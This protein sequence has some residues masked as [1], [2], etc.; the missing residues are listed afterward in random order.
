MF[1]RRRPVLNPS[2]PN[3]IGSFDK[4]V[5]RTLPVLNH[6]DNPGVEFSLGVSDVG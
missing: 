1:G 2:L 6:H 5:A 3:T 4:S